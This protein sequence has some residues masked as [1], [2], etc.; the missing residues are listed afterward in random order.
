VTHD[1][2][3]DMAYV[4]VVE[5]RRRRPSSRS[6]VDDVDLPGQVVIDIERDGRI[7]GFELFEGSRSLPVKLFDEFRE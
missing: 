7:R 5:P 4:R 2:E 1:P 6:S 3:A